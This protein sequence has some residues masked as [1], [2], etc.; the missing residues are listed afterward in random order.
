MD[1]LLS[2]LTHFLGNS[3]SYCLSHPQLDLANLAVPG[4]FNQDIWE[5]F[6]HSL[7]HVN[8]L[9]G[10]VQGN[11]NEDILGDFQKTFNHFVQT[12]Q[13]WALIIGLFLG[14][15]LRSLTSF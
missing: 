8:V 1:F 15:L 10:Q 11:F 6:W 4:N 13:V 14:Y 2:G 9:A 5:V 3:L 12:G 7:S